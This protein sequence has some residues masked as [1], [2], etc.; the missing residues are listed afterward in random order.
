MFQSIETAPIRKKTRKYE[1]KRKTIRKQEKYGNTSNLNANNTNNNKQQTKNHNFACT[2][3]SSILRALIT[4]NNNKNRKWFSLIKTLCAPLFIAQLLIEWPLHNN[5]CLYFSISFVPD[6][7]RSMFI[8][9]W[10]STRTEKRNEWKKNKYKKYENR[11]WSG[12]KKYSDCARNEK[13]SGN[14]LHH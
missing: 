6:S 2:R 9:E 8:C 7:I 12:R 11:N 13:K 3:R 4:T 1:R 14:I 5:I 10:I